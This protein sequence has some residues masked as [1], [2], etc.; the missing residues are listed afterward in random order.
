MTPAALEAPQTD[1]VEQRVATID[2]EARALTIRNDDDYTRAGE[3]LS[4]RIRPILKQI[5][6]VFDP[7]TKKAHEAHKAMIA[8][9]K[10][11]AAPLEAAM[12]H[13]KRLIADYAMQKEQER[14]AEEARL[15]REQIERETQERLARAAELESAGRRE[16][17]EAKLEEAIAAPA[18]APPVVLP[19]ATPKLVGIHTR[20][21]RRWR[22]VEPG[23]VKRPFLAI[24]EKKIG[25]LVRTMGFDAAVVVG[26]I[27]VYEEKVTVG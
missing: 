20:T 3:F 11:V 7:P 12:T 27:E 14:R 2:A 1:A 22:V 10:K 5:D 8:A 17:A 6:D 21:V 25:D 19:P 16:E 26:G 15:R 13:V 9:K 23:Q 4:E 24:D 18:V